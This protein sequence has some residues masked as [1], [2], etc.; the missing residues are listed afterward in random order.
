MNST[1]PSE[2]TFKMIPEHCNDECSYDCDG[3]CDNED[4]ANLPLYEGAENELQHK[5]EIAFPHSS[6]MINFT[7]PLTKPHSAEVVSPTGNFTYGQLAGAII[8]RYI[9]I[10]QDL[11]EGNNQWGVHSHDIDDLVL[12]GLRYDGS[13]AYDIN[14]S[15]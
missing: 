12:H 1:L 4:P 6:I 9:T 13:G 3:D 11:N 5:D 2:I 14:M 8:N 10:Y 7:Y 15:S